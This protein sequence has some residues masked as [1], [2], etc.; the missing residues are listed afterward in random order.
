GMSGL[1]LDDM[2]PALRQGQYGA[3]M[4]SAAVRIG[5]A[6]AKDQNVTIP[7][8]RSYR[9]PARVSRDS[10]PWPLI[11]LGI[12]IVLSLLRRGGGGYGG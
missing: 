9:P 7:P 6:I 8:P 4:I 1:L 5:A 10:L 11:L 3:A 12:F 2:R